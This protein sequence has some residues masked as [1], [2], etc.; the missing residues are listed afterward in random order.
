MGGGYS[1][2]LYNSSGLSANAS[3][4]GKMAH[5]PPGYHVTND[6]SGSGG[7]PRVIVEVLDS[8]NRVVKGVIF[9]VRIQKGHM[10][11]FWGTY[12][13]HGGSRS[14]VLDLSWIIRDDGVVLQKY[15]AGM[16]VQDPK[17]WYR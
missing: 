1:S 10:T 6:Y 16:R 13:P 9:G 11:P 2:H 15:G 12:I 3:L 4:W 8:K 14:N 5:L 17:L 7:D